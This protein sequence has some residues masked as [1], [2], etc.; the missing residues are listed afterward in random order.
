MNL[1]YW[2]AIGLVVFLIHNG[3]SL[4]FKFKKKKGQISISYLMHAKLFF[5]RL[6]WSSKY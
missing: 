4:F 1:F 2:L 5:E 3:M 6:P